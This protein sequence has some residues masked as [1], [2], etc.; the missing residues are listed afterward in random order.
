MASIICFK[1]HILHRMCC[2][3]IKSHIFVLLYVIV[4]SVQVSMLIYSEWR[5]IQFVYFLFLPWW[6]RY[7]LKQLLHA[8]I[9]RDCSL[10]MDQRVMSPSERVLFCTPPPPGSTHALY[11][12]VNPLK[13]APWIMYFFYQ[14]PPH[15]TSTNPTQSIMNSP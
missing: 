10:S 14:P 3:Q 11:T 15:L 5:I 8:A 9:I 13:W 2:S 1:V 4:Y 7:T 6:L 12:D